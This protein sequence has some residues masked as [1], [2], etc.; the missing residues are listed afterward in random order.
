MFTA[1]PVTQVGRSFLVSKSA[2]LFRVC[3]HARKRLNMR[4]FAAPLPFQLSGM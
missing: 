2:R 1:T 4:E 3:S